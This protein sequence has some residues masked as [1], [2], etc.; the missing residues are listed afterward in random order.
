[1]WA[2]VGS[3]DIEKAAAE[4]LF[5]FIQRPASTQTVAEGAETDD[6]WAQVGGQ[7][8]YSKVKESTG[9]APGFEPRLF[10]VSNTSGYMWMEELP[11]FAQEDL[12][13]D[14]CYILDAFNTIFC[15]IGNKSN[16]FEQKGVIKRA[17]KFLAEC[18][19]SRN[20]D[21]VIIEEVLAGREPP[22]FT[23]QFIQWEPE[24]AAKWLETDSQVLAE[25]AAEEQKVEEAAQAHAAANPF[26][27]FL[28]PATNPFPYETLKSSFP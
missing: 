9:F 23:V 13:N 8:E 15:W 7:G 1:M 22:A 19:D 11:A 21:D 10:S 5:D 2:G 14:D 6:F 18:R 26:E 27:G 24:V 17:E 3:N 28:D 20:K 25:A 4:K 16:K 12:L